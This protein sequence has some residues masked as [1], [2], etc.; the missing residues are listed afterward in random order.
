MNKIAG[1]LFNQIISFEEFFDNKDVGNL[2]STSFIALVFGLLI[3]LLRKQGFREVTLFGSLILC[4]VIWYIL[5]P[6]ERNNGFTDLPRVLFKKAWR[7]SRSEKVLFICCL[8][9][10]L[11]SFIA[12]VAYPSSQVKEYPLLGVFLNLVMFSLT[13]IPVPP[14]IRVIQ[15]LKSVYKTINVRK[16]FSSLT[17]IDS[18]VAFQI[19]H[20]E[21]ISDKLFEKRREEIEASADES[22]FIEKK[23]S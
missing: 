8:L 20:S 23:S 14:V 16:K 12:A 1:L 11:I 7:T 18:L 5:I 13:L 3:V 10:I 6:K 2:A 22:T 9:M 21:D 17:N 19:D 15:C 4:L